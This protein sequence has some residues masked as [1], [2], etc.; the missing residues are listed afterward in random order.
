MHI[1]EW[2]P[3]FPTLSLSL[4]VEMP[5]FMYLA[6]F[7][8]DSNLAYIPTEKH[9]VAASISRKGSR[10]SYQSTRPPKKQ[11]LIDH[12]KRFWALH[13]VLW[14]CITVLVVCLA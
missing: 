10:T 7:D 1:A 5:S 3:W 12:L 8:S 2:K 4:D 11:R 9:Q 6:H 13:L 14:I